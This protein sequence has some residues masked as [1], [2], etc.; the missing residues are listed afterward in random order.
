MNAEIKTENNAYLHKKY[1]YNVYILYYLQHSH[2]T[3]GISY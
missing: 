1:I 3:N 2:M